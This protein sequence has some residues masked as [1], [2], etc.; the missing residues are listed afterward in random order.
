MTD[1]RSA[2]AQIDRWG[3][4]VWRLALAR[5]RHIQ[6]S[7]D[8]FQEVFSR[9]FR[10]QEN[11]DSDEHRKAWL[12]R[13]TLNCTNTLLSAR[14]RTHLPLEEAVTQAMEPE[15][16]E[17]YQAVLALPRKYRTA[18][19]LHYYEGYSVTEI[20]ALTGAREGTVKSWLSRGREKLAVELKGDD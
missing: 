11:L 10:H 18:L 15:D 1:E 5:T 6:D 7:E 13:C 2:R 9:F 19:H 17:V 12:I 16:R 14:W 3:D 4:M 8:V 20:A